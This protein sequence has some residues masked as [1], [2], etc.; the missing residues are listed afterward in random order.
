MRKENTI[1]IY[2]SDCGSIVGTY[3]AN[4]EEFFDI[5]LYF[6]QEFEKFLKG[7][8]K[9]EKE[10][11]TEQTNGNYVFL[12]SEASLDD[13]I[14]FDEN[15]FMLEEGEEDPPIEEDDDWSMKKPREWQKYKK[16]AT[17]D[18]IFFVRVQNAQEDTLDLSFDMGNPKKIDI[19]DE[20]TINL[21]HWN[22][23]VD[24]VRKYGLISREQANELIWK[25]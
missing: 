2:P 14:D 18:T 10:K 12:F 9:K 7:V 25:E 20:A 11:Y 24:F 4:Y 3:R 21:S 17:P 6:K 13:D 16:A 5:L 23:I 22:S 15:E 19:S 8:P 1:D